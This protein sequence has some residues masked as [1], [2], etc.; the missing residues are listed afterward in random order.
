MT[1]TPNAMPRKVSPIRIAIL[2]GLI[3]T[4]PASRK[5]KVW[6]ADANNGK[7]D[8]VQTTIST[9]TALR[10][11]LAQNVSAENVDRLSRRWIA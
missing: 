2:G 1:I 3:E 4:R 10:Y 11:P 7:G 9:G 6:D 5:H 8:V